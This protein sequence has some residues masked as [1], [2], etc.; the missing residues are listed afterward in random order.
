MNLDTDVLFAL[1]MIKRKVGDNKSKRND[2]LRQ[3]LE[4]MPPEWLPDVIEIA[5]EIQEGRDPQRTLNLP[6]LKTTAAP[7]R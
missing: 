5:Q 1:S 7:R 4:G 2:K 6:P 3:F